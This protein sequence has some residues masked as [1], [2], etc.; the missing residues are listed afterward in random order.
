[1][2]LLLALLVFS[3]SA[4]RAAEDF[5]TINRD[6]LERFSEA[7]AH[8]QV[9]VRV[10]SFG[11]SMANSYESI[12]MHLVLKMLPKRPLAGV[13][14]NNFRNTAL[15]NSTNGTTIAPPSPFWFSYQF[16]V[17][18]GSSVWWENQADARGTLSDRLGL[19]W[20]A[21]PNGGT[22]DLQI[23][24]R[25]GAWTKVLTLDGYS[26]ALQGRVT[27]LTVALREYRLQVTSVTGTNY[28]IGPELVNTTSNGLH[29]AWMNY[30]GIDLAQVMAVP[31]AVRD[32]IL[33]A[34]APDLLIWHFK[35]DPA[36]PQFLTGLA[37]HEAWFKGASPQT[38]VL[39]IGTPYSE[40]AFGGAK[41]VDHNRGVR[42]LALENGR[43]YLDCMT[44]GISY[45]WLR[46]HGYT[47]D[48]V[49]PNYAGSEFLANIAWN[50]IGFYALGSDRQLSVGYG[51]RGSVLL[52]ANLA[53]GILYEFQAS[54]NLLDWTTFHTQAGT[55]IPLELRLERSGPARYY[56][57]HLLPQN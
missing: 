20:V 53:A 48:V 37:E 44:P 40:D 30:D 3:I 46:D 22:F 14:F 2:P 8:R 5:S 36:Q 52:N 25:G 27:N 45:E 55:A 39:Y 9:P 38:D 34:F 32:P 54:T 41:T 47:L 10:L 31:A 6:K 28:I 24:E 57:M 51:I 29:A 1:M 18:Q 11:D 26:A 50:D 56:R 21:Q 43:A 42:R 12:T 19:Y 17:P 16:R 33:G 23:S 4:T 35:E 13:S 15:W 49:H 7:F